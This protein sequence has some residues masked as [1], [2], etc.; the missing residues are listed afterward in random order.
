MSDNIKTFEE[1]EQ[2][3]ADETEG[4]V[5]GPWVT[6]AKFG[7]MMKRLA[8]EKGEP[9]FIVMSKRKKES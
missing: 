7:Q 9:I 1:F 3:V 5:V 6:A 4:T 8:K 2:R